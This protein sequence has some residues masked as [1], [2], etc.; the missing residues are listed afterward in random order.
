MVKKTH[1]KEEGFQMDSPVTP[2][3]PNFVTGQITL[4]AFPMEIA[5]QQGLSALLPNN[6]K[7]IQRHEIYLMPF[8]KIYANAHVLLG[9]TINEF[10]I[11][12]KAMK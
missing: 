3:K 2:E 10:P 9:C 7:I 12:P 5:I 6:V 4:G 8:L 1:L 11:Q